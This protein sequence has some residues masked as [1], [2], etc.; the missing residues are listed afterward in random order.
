MT[1][2]EEDSVS[3]MFLAMSDLMGQ[4][5]EGIRTSVHVTEH[6]QAEKECKRVVAEW[7][8]CIALMNHHLRNALQ[9]NQVCGLHLRRKPEAR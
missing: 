5:L 4:L 3:V 7:L 1:E 2:V 8:N 9:V 6:K